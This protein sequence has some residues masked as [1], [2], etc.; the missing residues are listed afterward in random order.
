MRSG[1][2]AV[3]LVALLP[4][5]T[6]ADPAPVSYGSD[7]YGPLPAFSV[8]AGVFARR[9]TDTAQTASYRGTSPGTGADVRHGSLRVAVAG[10]RWYLA[11]ELDIGSLTASFAGATT[12]DAM[13]NRQIDES[14]LTVFTQYTVGAG[15]RT[16]VGRV[17]VGAEVQ[18]GGR[19][20]DYNTLHDPDG[21]LVSVTTLVVEPRA[22]AELFAKP[23]LSLGASLGISAL[24]DRER[25]VG[26]TAALHSRAFDAA[27]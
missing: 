3:T 18:V 12:I 22:H 25:V 13:G 21:S 14:L 4:T 15:M 16:T 24:H 23:W 9:I 5:T 2:L 11:G 19:T 17:I 27:F 1:S 6:W 8:E 26:F 20:I 7:T 10:L